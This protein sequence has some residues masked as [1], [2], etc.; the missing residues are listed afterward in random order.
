MPPGYSGA[1]R[2]ASC[3]YGAYLHAVAVLVVTASEGYN[4]A[5]QGYRQSKD[6]SCSGEP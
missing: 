1:M 6:R 3:H 5:V 4:H 2:A